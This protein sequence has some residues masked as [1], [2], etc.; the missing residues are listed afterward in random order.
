M[1]TPGAVLYAGD[2]D[3]AMLGRSGPP[4]AA[5]AAIDPVTEVDH[6]GATG[7]WGRQKEQQEERIK[8]AHTHEPLD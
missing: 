4:T 5:A 8:P 2:V 7:G 6:E 1:A 3:V